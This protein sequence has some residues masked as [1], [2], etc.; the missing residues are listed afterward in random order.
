[1]LE[2]V[3]QEMEEGEL[4]ETFEEE[5][6]KDEHSDQHGANIPSTGIDSKTSL[7]S[8]GY[9]APSAITNGSA[10]NKAHFKLISM[11]T[12]LVND[13]ALKNLM[14]SWYYAGYYTGLY[15]GQQ[16]AS[17]SKES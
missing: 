14:M 16:R 17:G 3:D 15:E 7:P 12:M 9:A 2:E 10:S 11:L 13:D 6:S 1:M 5:T 4:D 8:A